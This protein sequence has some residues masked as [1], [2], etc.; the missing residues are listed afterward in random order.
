MDYLLE[1][2]LYDHSWNVQT[3]C[4][5]KYTPTSLFFFGGTRKQLITDYNKIDLGV[6]ERG[7]NKTSFRIYSRV[8]IYKFVLVLC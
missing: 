1:L 2:S 4:K 3:K 5:N 8:G 7:Y 6:G